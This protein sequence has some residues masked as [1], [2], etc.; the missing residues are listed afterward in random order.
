MLLKYFPGVFP[1]YYSASKLKTVLEEIQLF[2]AAVVVEK[3]KLYLLFTISV[4]K[5]CDLLNYFVEVTQLKG[6]FLL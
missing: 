4:I 2:T 5:R 1:L 3:I 6:T